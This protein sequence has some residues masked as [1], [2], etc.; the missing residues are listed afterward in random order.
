MACE[1]QK[2]E[3]ATYI[4]NL[5]QFVAYEL[6]VHDAVK[7]QNVAL[8]TDVCAKYP[9]FINMPDSMGH[10]PLDMVASFY[11]ETEDDVVFSPL[12]TELMQHEAVALLMKDAD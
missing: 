9:Q 12:M 2:H 11:A 4:L 7:S 8:L 3:F 5:P 1:Y 10:T 6:I